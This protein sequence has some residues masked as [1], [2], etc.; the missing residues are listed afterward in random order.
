MCRITAFYLRNPAHEVLAKIF[1]AHRD[2]SI[3]DP[4][5][6]AISSRRSHLDGWGY[7]IASRR[8]GAL[9]ISFS[10]YGW[11]IDTECSSRVLEILVERL[12]KVDEVVGVLHSRAASPGQPLGDVAAH[13]YHVTV[14]IGGEQ[15]RVL[16]DAWSSWLGLKHLEEAMV[17]LTRIE[18]YIRGEA[19][20]VHL[21]VAHNGS[22]DREALAKALRIKSVAMYTDSH[23]LAL[24]LAKKL[25][26][27]NRFD[28]KLLASILGEVFDSY[29]PSGTALNVAM[30]AYRPPSDVELLLCTRLKNV[31]DAKREYY[32][33]VVAR[34]GEGIVVASSTV[35]D[36]LEKKGVRVEDLEEGVWRLYPEVE[37]LR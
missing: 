37:K 3:D 30:L 14:V 33:M 26:E 28:A 4:K 29:T 20:V 2:A 36:L 27:E 10:K 13:P 25:E 5:L 12:S 16:E 34:L 1:E 17:L 15:R 23:L 31:S 19:Q 35:G 6:A 32:R 18:S 9:S 21:F 11:G 8:K 24:Y 22:V 7:A